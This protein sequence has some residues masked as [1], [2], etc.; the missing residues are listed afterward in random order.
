M[1]GNSVHKENLDEKFADEINSNTKQEYFGD[2][3]GDNF[4]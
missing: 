3:K 4:I 1:R 2:T